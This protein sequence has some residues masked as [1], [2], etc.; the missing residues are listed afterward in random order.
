M[1]SGL[2]S[3]VR[4]TI[5][6]LHLIVITSELHGSS[7]DSENIH[8]TIKNGLFVNDKVSVTLLLLDNIKFLDLKSGS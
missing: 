1:R 7:E 2:N 3:F 6:F 8:K 4:I 5:L